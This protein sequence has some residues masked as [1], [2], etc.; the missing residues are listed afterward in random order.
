MNKFAEL[1]N[2]KVDFELSA[3]WI[4]LLGEVVSFSKS[5]SEVDV[6]PLIKLKKKKSY[7]RL[8]V[9]K[10][11]VGLS[12]GNGFFL[13]PDYKKG[14]IVELKGN[15]YP[16]DNQLK[17][18]VEVAENFK[19]KLSNCTIIKSHVKRPKLIS[20]NLIK[21]GVVIAHEDGDYFQLKKDEINFKT[22]DFTIESG[23]Q[24]TQKAILGEDTVSLLKD[25][26]D[27][28]LDITVMTPVGPSS[29]ISTIATNQTKLNQIKTELENLYSSG[30]KFN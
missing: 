1:M 29:P 3:I 2:E 13:I 27:T 10:C 7:T 24:S 22:K 26:I 11:P 14:D 16:I 28:I 9:I 21:D 20:P 19:F 15:I 4:G 5:K 12:L 17:G 18:Q 23:I 8:P 25:L 6:Q 30:V